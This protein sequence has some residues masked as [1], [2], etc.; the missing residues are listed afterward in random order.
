MGV[1]AVT[2]LVVLLYARA[3]AAAPITLPLLGGNLDLPDGWEVRGVFGQ[4]DVLQGPSGQVFLGLVADC[5]AYLQ[6]EAPFEGLPDG[7]RGMVEKGQWKACRDG[8]FDVAIFSMNTPAD[9]AAIAPLLESVSGLWFSSPLGRLLNVVVLPGSKL[10]TSHIKDGLRV[11][12]TGAGSDT[13]VMDRTPITNEPAN[14]QVEFKIE[15]ATSCA[16]AAM[17]IAGNPSD[18]LAPEGWARYRL[19]TT[20][21]VCRE[22]GDLAI[23]V[24]GPEEEELERVFGDSG[25]MAWATVLGPLVEEQTPVPEL[26]EAVALPRSGVR[27][28]IPAGFAIAEEQ[29]PDEQTDLVL[30]IGGEE[31]LAP[32]FY[33]SGDVLPCAQIAENLTARGGNLNDAAWIPAGW[34]GTSD[35]SYCA[36]I[37]ERVVSVYAPALP[38][39]LI[40]R[41][42]VALRDD[43]TTAAEP[44]VTSEVPSVGSTSSYRPFRPL[45]PIP[46]ELALQTSSVEGTRGWGARAALDLTARRRHWSAGIRGELGWDSEAATSYDVHAHGTVT[47]G[48]AFRLIAM[49]GNDAYGS[50][51][52][53]A[54]QSDGYVAL[55]AGFGSTIDRG[56]IVFDV[57]RHYRIIEEEERDDPRRPAKEWRL[58]SELVWGEGRVSGVTADY[59][60]VG[61]AKVF[62]LGL[63]IRI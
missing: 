10:R 19:G 28:R 11:A 37:G 23:V 18:R 51:D 30:Q 55:G 59:R 56:W 14:G 36:T 20:M 54:V 38:R 21:I 1:G 61:L 26:G 39:P 46:I 41:V 50:G 35:A 32:S 6:G 52:M 5:D 40:E 44:A 3:S 60:S 63:V 12:K 17:V 27:L 48:A 58:R 43:N 57:T 53:P 49:L 45:L 2:A 24:S 13:L 33:V 34:I 7:W 25:V 31:H 8:N 22:L 62:L 15:R 47:L 9:A 42:L 16:N 29:D 4:A